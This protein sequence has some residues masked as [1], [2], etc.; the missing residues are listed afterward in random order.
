M[1][2]QS[3]MTVWVMS[4]YLAVGSNSDFLR[5]PLS[6][7]SALKVL[8][9]FHGVLPTKKLVDEI[10]QQAVLH[11]EPQPLPDGPSMSSVGYY[12]KH[13]RLIEA[14]RPPL[15]N[16]VLTSGQKKDIVLSNR[17]LE[18]EN[19]IAIYGWHRTDG[20]PIQ[21]L[22][23]VHKAEYEDYS[24]GVR[25]VSQT[26]WQNGRPRSILEV[27]HDPESAPLLTYE[28]FFPEIRKMVTATN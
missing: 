14:Q 28:G 12:L 26:V 5:V 4:D 16:D 22:S 1:G 9:R 15:F 13:Q 10:Y 25:F 3:G 7:Q 6:Y 20:K 21:P 11:V 8:H 2:G 27:L 18:K 19:R 24:H 23:I 17:L